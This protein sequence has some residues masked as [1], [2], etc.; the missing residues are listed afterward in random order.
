MKWDWE[1]WFAQAAPDLIVALAT[2]LV[3]ATVGAAIAH[4]WNLRQRSRELDLETAKEFHTHYG[5]FFATWKLWNY[6]L[7]NAESVIEKDIHWQLLSRAS[8]A[9]GG[10][11][12]ILSKLASHRRLSD[13]MVID[14]ACFRQAFQRLRE[15][16]RKEAP[17]NWYSSD[18][19][20]Y[21][22][23]KELTGRV[24]QL[25][26]AKRWVLNPVRR[27]DVWARVTDNEWEDIWHDA[28]QCAAADA[29]KRRG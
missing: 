18:V 29:A 24:S 27:Q 9:E 19:P 20:E 22:R 12:S 25:I 7:E 11:E 16:I 17:L 15:C 26:Y 3:V 5:E 6:Y 2:G 13:Q 28:Q 1:T 4:Y 23:F 21:A 10:M 8:A 14:L